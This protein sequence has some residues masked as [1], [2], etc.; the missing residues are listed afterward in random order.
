L[1]HI[2][3]PNNASKYITEN[4]LNEFFQFQDDSALNI[5][6]INCRSLKKNFGSLNILLQ[7]L[8]DK[9]SA[10]AVTETWL[11]ESLQHAYNILGYN[12]V[13]NS[14][15]DRCGGGVGIFVNNNFDYKIRHDL[16]RMSEYIES[17]FIEIRR[18]GKQ[19]IIIGCIYRPP[20]TD[21][22]LF[23]SELQIIL[24]ALDKINN[25]VAVLAGDFNLNLLKHSSH[26]PTDEFLNL[27]FSY[28]FIPTICQPTRITDF[29]A[30]LID[31]IFVH[32][33]KF[34]FNSAIL[35]S[36]ISDHLPVA[37]HLTASVARV[38]QA[39]N[40]SRRRTFDVNSIDKFN[41]CL[42]TTDWTF[43]YDEILKSSDASKVYDFFF[44]AYKANF[45]NCFPEITVKK[46]NRMTPRHEWMTKGLMKSCVRKSNL[47]KKYCQNK[48]K[49][50][51][52]KTLNIVYNKT[53]NI[54]INLQIFY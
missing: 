34:N 24:N 35:Y 50:N 49:Y 38:K 26:Q 40:M 41:R 28:N 33:L 5:I 42:A 23:I 11:T 29:T 48:S 31:N 32:C 12:L 53:L 54:V 47:Y 18:I 52:D 36:D 51:K 2:N 4:K 16:S 30:T 7:S 17:I 21:V 22:S 8:A 9:L 15:V 13:T 27:L 25:K 44:N 37:L 20:N 6:H 19:I 43:V 39:N 46:S 1:L 14:R 45:D 10:I 3:I